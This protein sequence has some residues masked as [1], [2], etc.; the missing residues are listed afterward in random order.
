M[1]HPSARK[2]R[3]RRGWEVPGPLPPGDQG[4]PHLLP[5][6]D[7]SLDTLCGHW[8][9]F[10]AQRGHRWSTD[11]L[12]AAWYTCH[13]LQ[14]HQIDPTHLL[15]LGSGLGTVSFLMAWRY[16]SL[17]AC[18]YEVQED[19]LRRARRSARWN[20]ISHRVHFHRGDLRH[21][22]QEVAPSPLIVGT[23]PYWD[24]R[25]GRLS[26]SSQKVECRFEA[27]SRVEDYVATAARLLTPDGL[28]GLVYDGRQKHRLYDAARE[29]GLVRVG[30]REVISR[31]GDPP[32]LVVSMWALRGENVDEDPPL[33]LRLKNNDRSD[34]FKKIRGEMGLPPGT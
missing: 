19:S 28:F 30:A 25:A 6:V 31:E 3:A 29:V 16:P 34:E 15:E 32:L 11:D 14:R 22:P 7:E 12:L 24:L 23:P 1:V 2:E 20:G 18:G 21:L 4:D 33:T 9:L 10:Q 13:V 26:P 27:H 17:V 5:A 8:C